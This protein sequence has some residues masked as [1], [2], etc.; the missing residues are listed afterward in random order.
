MDIF[1]GSFGQL[2]GKAK[3]LVPVKEPQENQPCYENCQKRDVRIPIISVVANP[4][5]GPVPKI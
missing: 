4:W 1:E 5:I 2:C 3:R